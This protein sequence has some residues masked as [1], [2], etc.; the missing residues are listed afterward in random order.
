MVNHNVKS[1]SSIEVSVRNV[2]RFHPTPYTLKNSSFGEALAVTNLED[3][4]RRSRNINESRISSQIRNI[5]TE[6]NKFYYLTG[7]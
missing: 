7:K 6:E 1:K 2:C 3:D 4:E 5:Q